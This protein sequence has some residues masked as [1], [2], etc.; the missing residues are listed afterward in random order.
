MGVLHRYDDGADE[1]QP[2]QRRRYD[3]TSEEESSS[4]HSSCENLG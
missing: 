3:E 2:G 4:S 1:L